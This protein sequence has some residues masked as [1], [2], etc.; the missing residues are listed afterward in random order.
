MVNFLINN[1]I[2]LANSVK[3]T[4][5]LVFLVLFLLNIKLIFIELREYIISTNPKL[6]IRGGKSGLNI[7][8]ESFWKVKNNFTYNTVSL[9]K[10]SS[11]F[12]T[13]VDKKPNNFKESFL[14]FSEKNDYTFF[15]YNAMDFLGNGL[16]N[17]NF[18]YDLTMIHNQF[19]VMLVLAAVLYY[20]SK[21][22]SKK[23]FNLE[24]KSAYECGFEP[25]LILTTFIEVGFILVAFIF[26]I[27]DLELIFLSAFLVASGS[28]GSAG[29]LLVI[30]YLASVWIMIFFEVF[31]GVLSWPVWN[32][33][34]SETVS[35]SFYS[36]FNSVSTWRDLFFFL[37]EVKY[38]KKVKYDWLKHSSFVP[39]SGEG[40]KKAISIN[41]KRKKKQ[42]DEAF[43]ND[44]SIIHKGLLPYEKNV[45]EI[46]TDFI[47]TLKS[48]SY[49]VDAEFSVINVNEEENVI[50][51][52]GSPCPYFRKR[53]EM[54][55][56]L[57]E[58]L[59]S[60]N[61][62]RSLESG[63]ERTPTLNFKIE[64]IELDW[65][66]TCM[67]EEEEAS[68][69]LVDDG[70]GEPYETKTD[71]TWGNSSR[72]FTLRTLMPR[73][74]VYNLSF[75]STGT[76]EKDISNCFKFSRKNKVLQSEELLTEFILLQSWYGSA[77]CSLSFWEFSS[78]V[79]GFEN[80]F[81]GYWKPV[82]YLKRYA[83][84]HWKHFIG[85]SVI[86]AYA[87][88]FP[89]KLEW[90]GFVRILGPF[91]D[92]VLIRNFHREFENSSAKNSFLF[93]RSD[94]NVELFNYDFGNIKTSRTIPE[95]VSDAEFDWWYYNVLDWSFDNIHV[96]RYKSLDLSPE[97]VYLAKIDFILHY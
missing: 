86:T 65:E 37:T 94:F 24:K 57:E 33:F 49:L 56:D 22:F 20:L 3:L 31:S 35:S 9:N 1:A 54:L 83:K 64:G 12:A 2:L 84:R 87:R 15:N 19:L 59:S 27:F 18:M 23:I 62:K 40:A 6:S 26:L 71:I 91:I 43:Y 29:I 16:F 13:I 73:H 92:P 66:T 60:V 50:Y 41:Y 80:M 36:L 53:I 96:T 82:T 47:Y 21:I 81:T 4:A 79:S 89:T 8:F 52:T 7:P 74:V 78:I 17:Q 68:R 77:G 14:L 32:I 45:S 61:R 55:V 25:F 11:I 95:N 76:F 63:C 67:V 39:F 38:F 48:A 88:S 70:S 44:L 90:N 85:D 46:L 75:Y 42:E 69:I 5:A 28:I 34:K 51:A 10:D 72:L 58:Y 30:L 93:F 97:E